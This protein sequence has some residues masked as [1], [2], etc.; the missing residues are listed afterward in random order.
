MKWLRKIFGNE[1]QSKKFG[2]TAAQIKPL[3]TGFGACIATD[4][5]TVHGKKV[6]F[7]VREAATGPHDSGWCFTSGEESQDYMDNPQNHGIYDVN[8]IAN[9]CPDITEHLESPPHSA[10]VRDKETGKLVPIEYQPPLA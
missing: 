3:A 9:Y 2:L 1:P 7:M 6:G 8:T 10:F 5:I 4:M